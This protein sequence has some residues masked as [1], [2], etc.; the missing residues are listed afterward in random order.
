MVRKILYKKMKYSTRH[1]S[2]MYLKSTCSF[3][4]YCK[5]ETKSILIL[6]QIEIEK[7]N[8]KKQYMLHLCGIANRKKITHSKSRTKLTHFEFFFSK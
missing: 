3:K 4:K 5:L 2:Y 8:P 1:V 6:D 7:K